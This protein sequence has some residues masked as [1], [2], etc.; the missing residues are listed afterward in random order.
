MAW[1]KAGKKKHLR[2]MRSC[3]QSSCLMTK[4]GHQMKE[5][6]L[7]FMSILVK[8]ITIFFVV[9]I[10]DRPMKSPY[11]GP[12]V[13]YRDISWTGKLQCQLTWPYV[14]KSPDID[15][16]L[17]SVILYIQ[18][19]HASGTHIVSINYYYSL[20]DLLST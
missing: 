1:M 2:T 10:Y 8:S 15:G 18:K 5:L 7:G 12:I 11:R 19:M 17:P 20:F 4:T 14:V 3:T 13:P 16:I 9:D 6:F